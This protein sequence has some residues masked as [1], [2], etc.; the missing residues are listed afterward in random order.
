MTI[1]PTGVIT[2]H[3]L[4]QVLPDRPFILCC[5]DHHTVW[6][7]T[8]ALKAAD[9]LHGRDLPPGNEIVMGPDGLALGELK[10]FAAY[11]PVFALTRRRDASR[12][13]SP[14]AKIRCRPQ[15]TPTGA[16]TRP[17]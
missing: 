13:A 9:I 12:S 2:R 10:E 11:G 17:P 15:A 8:A 4:D 3:D 1:R 6:A 14:P 7:N 16:P 5:F